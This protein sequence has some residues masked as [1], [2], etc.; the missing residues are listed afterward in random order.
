ML[1]IMIPLTTLQWAERE[2]EENRR[3][4][5]NQGIEAPKNVSEEETN[6]EWLVLNRIREHLWEKRVMVGEYQLRARGQEECKRKLKQVLTMS[7]ITLKICFVKGMV[8]TFF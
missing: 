1:T 8:D 3:D 5:G 2:V 6:H 7:Q 4:P